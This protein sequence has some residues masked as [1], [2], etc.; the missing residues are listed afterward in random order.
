MPLLVLLSGCSGIY[1]HDCS[2]PTVTASAWEGTPGTGVRWEDL[3][4]T[5]PNTE[6]LLD[7]AIEGHGNATTVIPASEYDGFQAAMD[8]A[9]EETGR[10]GSRPV[11]GGIDVVT[12]QS[13][14]WGLYSQRVCE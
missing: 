14:E 3:E 12:Y 9:W 2:D 5:F 1:E 13:Q 4:G 10:P 7:A 11:V 6:D 8:D